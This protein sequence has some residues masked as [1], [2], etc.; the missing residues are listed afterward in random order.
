MTGATGMPVMC[1]DVCGAVY[2]TVSDID[3]SVEPF[4]SPCC[5]SGRL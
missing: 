4:L 3:V 5:C 1:E 2:E